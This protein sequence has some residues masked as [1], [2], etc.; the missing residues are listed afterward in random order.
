MGA[1]RES[2]LFKILEK[3]PGSIEFHLIILCVRLSCPMRVLTYVVQNS[4]TTVI[5]PNVFFKTIPI[6]YA[7]VIAQRDPYPFCFFSLLNHDEE[8][9]YAFL[10]ERFCTSELFDCFLKL[11][12]LSSS[13]KKKNI[14][15]Y[16]KKYP[17]M[18]RFLWDTARTNKSQLS[19]SDDS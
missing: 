1:K 3:W 13:D 4:R 17:A 8:H 16:V 15:Y 12:F 14:H 6:E 10:R 2:I 7:H 18:S 19:F 11:N 9:I 5:A